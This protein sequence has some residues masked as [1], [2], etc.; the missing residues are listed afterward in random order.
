MALQPA[1]VFQSMLERYPETN[2]DEARKRCCKH[3]GLLR[4][5]DIC[6]GLR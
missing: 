1:Q 4:Y 3:P 6:D 2:Q 5:Q